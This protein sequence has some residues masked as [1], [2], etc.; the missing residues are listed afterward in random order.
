MNDKRKKEISAYMLDR[1]LS[2]YIE[3]DWGFE[4][5]NDASSILE[6]LESFEDDLSSNPPKSAAPIVEIWKREWD[7]NGTGGSQFCFH[8]SDGELVLTSVLRS[9]NYRYTSCPQQSD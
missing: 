6:I 1:G 4:L 5:W 7:R 9:S 8:N 3:D 2:F